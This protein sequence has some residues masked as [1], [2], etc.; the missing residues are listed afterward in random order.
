MTRLK[1]FRIFREDIGGSAPANNAVATPGI[2]SL[3][4]ENATVGKKRLR[5]V[6]RRSKACE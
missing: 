6:I 4:P 3:Q 2:D 1:K 5:K